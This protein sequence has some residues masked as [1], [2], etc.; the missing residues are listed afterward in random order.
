M[1]WTTLTQ[2][3]IPKAFNNPISKFYTSLERG[4]LFLKGSVVLLR[5]LISWISTYL[6]KHYCESPFFEGV[7]LQAP[8]DSYHMNLL[9][10]FGTLEPSS[11][12]FPQ[13][14]LL[15]RTY[16]KG[17]RF[18]QHKSSARHESHESANIKSEY[19]YFLRWI[20]PTM[21]QLIF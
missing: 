10:G 14:L 7:L 3:S 13:I 17:A 21:K 19:I 9:W 18:L 15:R 1:D 16:Q 20:N 4:F 6:T 12:I 5:S 11:G 8:C 2:A